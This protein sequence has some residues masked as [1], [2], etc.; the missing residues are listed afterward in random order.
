MEVL[1]RIALLI[2]ATS[3]F[4]AG[5][6]LGYR[7]LVGAQLACFSAGALVLLFTFLSQF[8]RFKGPFKIE[9]EMWEREME[10]A[11]EIAEKFRNLAIVVAKPL[12]ASGVRMGRMSSHLS[13]REVDEMVTEVRT[14]LEKSGSPPEDIEAA[15]RDYRRFTAFDM[16]R[17]ARVEVKKVLD[18]K[19]QEKRAVVDAFRGVIPADQ[20][21]AYNAAANEV[22]VA[23][24]SASQVLDAFSI[25]H[26]D[27]Y[28]E[29]IR[30]RVNACDLLEEEEKQSL[31]ASFQ[32]TL[33]DLVYFQETGKIRR[34]E[35]WFAES[36]E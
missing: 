33:D 10:E 31:L 3:L 7:D 35:V 32:D 20:N 13:R 21:E 24:Q 9:G 17:T 8:K 22:R 6:N 29:T 18:A 12:I 36:E 11:Q 14:I 27:S 26:A 5:V 23:Q 28:L 25:D 4:G 2:I 16:V 30:V 19:V 34:P 1:I 15:L